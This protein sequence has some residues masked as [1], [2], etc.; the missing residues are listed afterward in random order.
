MNQQQQDFLVEI[1]FQNNKEWFGENSMIEG[2]IQLSLPKSNKSSLEEEEIYIKEI[3]L[4]IQGNEKLEYQNPKPSTTA[5]TTTNPQNE[6]ITEENKILESPIIIYSSSISSSSSF[7]NSNFN[8]LLK[9]N[10]NNSEKN[11]FHFSYKLPKDLPGS[12]YEETIHYG[13]QIKTQIAYFTSCVVDYVKLTKNSINYFNTNLNTNNNTNNNTNKLNSFN[14]K[15]NNEQDLQI[16]VHKQF[17]VFEQFYDKKTSKPLFASRN[18]TNHQILWKISGG[19]DI[20]F[21]KENCKIYSE[22]LN[23][24][25]LQINH[26][27][28]KLYQIITINMNTINSN[29]RIMTEVFRKSFEGIQPRTKDIRNVVFPLKSSIGKDYFIYPITTNGKLIKTEYRLTFS[30]DTLVD[31]NVPIDIIYEQELKVRGNH[32]DQLKQKRKSKGFYG[33]LDDIEEEQDNNDV[34]DKDDGFSKVNDPTLDDNYHEI[35]FID[36]KNRKSIKSGGVNRRS[37]EDNS[38]GGRSCGCCLM[39]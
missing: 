12:F 23:E 1:L 28:V 36:K 30:L 2:D 3:I 26:L 15:L 14:N 11:K 6:W 5:T 13:K 21:L 32:K 18:D 39:M 25:F 29:E 22:I 24:N 20:F 7:E 19:K 33:E 16:V 35:I 37:I 31:I 17:E 9:L 34:D 38:G 4:Y 8:K 10:N 27:I